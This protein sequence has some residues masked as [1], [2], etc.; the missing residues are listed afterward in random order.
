MNK[1]G[2]ICEFNPFHNGHKFLLQNIKSNYADDIICIMSG[3]FVQRGDIAICDKYT[4]TK[5]ALNNGADMV[6]ELPTVYAVSNSNIFAENG[7]LMAKS[8]GCD[9][10][11]FGAEDKLDDLLKISEFLESY[12]A[13]NII[14]EQMT[15]GEYYP[16]A[17]YHAIKQTQGEDLANISK[18]PNNILALEYISACK[19]HNIK[20]IAIKRTGTNH[21]SEKTVDIYTSASNIRKMI[22][23]GESYENFTPMKI[24]NYAE[25]EK[26]E[27]AIL[28]KIKTSS[29]EELKNL[30][31]INEG[32][33]N[34][35]IKIARSKNSINELL[36][37]LKTK[38]YTHARLR[39]IL[40]Y[41][42]LAI[43]NE[44][45]HTPVPYIRVLGI[46]KNKT[47]L[48]KSWD[49][50]LITK[51][52]RG[53]KALNFNAQKIFNVDIKTSEIFSIALQSKSNIS[54]NEFSQQIIKV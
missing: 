10:L 20:P 53:Y 49:L 7:V 46:N 33:E 11:C 52:S 40:I 1:A 5:A 25:L 38:R 9:I 45:Q 26:I 24:K 31:D 15:N 47:Y 34:R 50:P 32:L 41:S 16:K 22:K 42:L 48:M 13:Q 8:L 12:D 6:V 14:K 30:A 27:S 23:N 44:M 37:A 19:K 21:D 51:V 2:V 29:A 3:H 35:I 36:S 54:L 43:S 28:Y 39:R 18:K 4:R 17:L